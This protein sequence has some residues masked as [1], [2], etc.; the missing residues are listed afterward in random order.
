[1]DYKLPLWLE[2]FF[3]TDEELE[4]RTVVDAPCGN[5]RYVAEDDGNVYLILDDGTRVL[6]LSNV[7]TIGD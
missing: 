4:S 1:M 6:D 5:K 3:L 2:L 7:R